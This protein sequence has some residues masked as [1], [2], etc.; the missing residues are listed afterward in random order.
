ML[1]K[2]IFIVIFNVMCNNNKSFSPSPPPTLALDGTTGAKMKQK[3]KLMIKLIK[4]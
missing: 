1:A 3:I 2:I 4:G